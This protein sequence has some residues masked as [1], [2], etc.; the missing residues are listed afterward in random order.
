MRGVAYEA[1]VQGF[2]PSLWLERKRPGLLVVYS[3]LSSS[4]GSE[5]RSHKP[6]QQVCLHSP[7]LKAA[8]PVAARTTD[9][10]AQVWLS[11]QAPRFQWPGSREL[12]LAECLI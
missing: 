1:G 12:G 8:L 10:A 6:E 2:A 11:Q 4:L 3:S 7:E 9:L 5:A